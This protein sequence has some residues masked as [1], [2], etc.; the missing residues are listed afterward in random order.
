MVGVTS[1]FS[2]VANPRSGF[3]STKSE[4]RG[5]KLD[6]LEKLT[7]SSSPAVSFGAAVTLVG[8]DFGRKPGGGLV[9]ANCADLLQLALG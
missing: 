9:L 6:L 2:G 5:S 8:L 7:S 4:E 1:T 3:G